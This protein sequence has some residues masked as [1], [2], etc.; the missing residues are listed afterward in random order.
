MNRIAGSTA[1]VRR[2]ESRR[3]TVPVVTTVLACL[4][5]LF[6]LVATVPLVPDIGFLVLI[7]WRLLRPEI[8]VP[9]IALGFGLFDDL[10]SGHPIGQSMA[11][12]T[13]I[14]LMFELIDSRIGYK[15]FWIDWLYATLAII[16]HTAASWYVARLMDSTSAFTL[17]LPQI[18]IAVLLYPVLARLVLALDRWRLAQ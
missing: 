12:W 8:W 2:R 7:T 17:L 9:S 13:I 6:P 14:F 16:L 15:D 1:A 3:R 11:L 10:V 18:G 5:G 4:L